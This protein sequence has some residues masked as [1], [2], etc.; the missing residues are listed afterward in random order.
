MAFKS[1]DNNKHS[2]SVNTDQ[3]RFAL[4]QD[5]S[6]YRTYAKESRDSYE[7]NNG[8]K[9]YRSFAVIPDI[10]AIDILTK[11]QIDINASDFMSDKQQVTKLKKIIIS[12]YPDLLTHGHSRR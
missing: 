1:Q 4:S 3:N 6:A 2:F 8:G 11:Y 5:I 12:D 10:V 9:S 7:Q